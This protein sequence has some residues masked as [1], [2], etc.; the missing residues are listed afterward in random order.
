[1]K[2]KLK[3]PIAIILTVAMIAGLLADLITLMPTKA[4]VIF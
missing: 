3:K 2:I 1:M 4:L